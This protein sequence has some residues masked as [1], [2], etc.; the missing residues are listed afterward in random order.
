M[1][2]NGE[3]TSVIDEMLRGNCGRHRC[4]GSAIASMRASLFGRSCGPNLIAHVTGPGCACADFRPTRGGA[5]PLR[6][7]PSESV[8]P[9]PPCQH[10]KRKH[11][12]A[13]APAPA[14]DRR[15]LAPLVPGPRNRHDHAGAQPRQQRG[16]KAQS[17]TASKKPKSSAQTTPHTH[18]HFFTLFGVTHRRVKLRRFPRV[19]PPSLLQLLLHASGPL[20]L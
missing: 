8:A 10:P 18:T 19:L 11:L 6:I 17:Q 20:C 3:C 13:P 15:V 2:L 7:A 1:V 9:Q 12:R 5:E 4:L 14:H 16:G